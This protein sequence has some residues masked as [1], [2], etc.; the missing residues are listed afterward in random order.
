MGFLRPLNPPIRRWDGQRVWIVGASS[1]IGAALA[2]ALAAR[3]A[4]VALSAR[5]REALED[6]AAD[7]LVAL[8]NDR[9]A[10]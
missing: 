7:H 3:G 9:R 1:G 6:I 10:A 4:W 8:I 5:R 2:R